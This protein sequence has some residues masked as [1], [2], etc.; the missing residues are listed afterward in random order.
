MQNSGKWEI[1]FSE[2]ERR[3]GDLVHRCFRC[4]AGLLD[5]GKQAVPLSSLYDLSGP[6]V[7]QDRGGIQ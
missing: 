1:S 4:S 6:V 3:S 5:H 2:E 7:L